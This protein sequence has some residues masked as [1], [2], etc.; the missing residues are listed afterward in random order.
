MG[1]LLVVIGCASPEG[2][3][4]ASGGDSASQPDAGP[5]SDVGPEIDAG[6][7]GDGGSELDAG[8]VD[9]GLDAG[10]DAGVVRTDAGTPRVDA[11]PPAPTVVERTY[12]IL[13]W[14]IAGGAE[15]GCATAGITRAVRRYVAENDVDFVSLNEVCRAQ[16]DAIEAALRAEWGLGARAQFGAYVGDDLDRVVGN[17]IF[18]RFGIENVTRNH[19]GRDMYGDRNLLCGRVP[20]LTHVRFCSAHL[21][22]ADGTARTQMGLVLER[23]EDWWMN[24]SDTVIL[25]GDLNLNADHAGLDPVYSSAA[26]TRNNG[27]NRGR[28]RELDDADPDHCI[29][30]GERS[31]AG[32]GGPCGEGGKIDF[33]FV[34]ENRIVDGSYS[35]DTFNVPDDCTGVCSDH[36]AVFGRVRVRVLAD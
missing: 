17:S 31:H 20:D 24:R 10:R 16:H 25:A 12:R 30:Y 26:N 5:E 19:L 8:A 32:S 14:N 15:N 6:S 33:I 7:E 34:R 2:R 23:I 9:P 28:Y 4:D 13:H 35:G 3:T 21:T 22:P 36:R 29:G 18:S 27:G 11:G 1:S